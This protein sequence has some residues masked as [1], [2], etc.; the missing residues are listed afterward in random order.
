M[1]VIRQKITETLTEYEEINQLNEGQVEKKNV[2][3]KFVLKIENVKDFSTKEFPT[4]E[5]NQLL[6]NL[7]KRLWNKRDIFETRSN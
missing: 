7:F 5:L 3:K 1:L 6:L 2:Q 4:Y